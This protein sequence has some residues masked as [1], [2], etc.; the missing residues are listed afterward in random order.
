[1][2][3]TLFILSLFVHYAQ[4]FSQ[5]RIDVPAP[6]TYDFIRYGNIP[7]SQYT[8]GLDFSVP[9]YQYSDNDFNFGVDVR[10]NSSGFKPNKRSSAVGLDWFL[11]AGGSITRS[12]NG[13]PDDIV[14][15]YPGGTGAQPITSGFYALAKT[16]AFANRQLTDNDFDNLSSPDIRIIV[17]SKRYETKPDIFHF[18]F[19]GFSGKFFLDITGEI[20]V[21]ADGNFK[22]DLTDFA[23]QSGDPYMQEEYLM[24]SKIVITDDKG[25]IYTF[26]GDLQ[27]LEYSVSISFQSELGFSPRITSWNLSKIKAP[28]GR[29]VIFKYKDFIKPKINYPI[30]Q[31]H[32]LINA[33]K[34]LFMGYM[35]EIGNGGER[36]EEKSTGPIPGFDT[37]YGATKTCYLE[38][39]TVD[40]T[41]INFNYLANNFTF[42]DSAKLTALSRSVKY[43]QKNLRLD[44]IQI[45]YNSV[46]IKEF[47]LTQINNGNRLFLTQIGEKNA[48]P[49]V[50]AYDNTYTSLPYPLTSY[51]DY[52]GFW[53]GGPLNDDSP[54]AF[55][56]MNY[57]VNGD[58]T[59]TNSRRDPNNYSRAGLLTSVTYPTK[60]VSRFFY[61]PHSYA[62]MLDRRSD[63]QFFP[64]LYDVNNLIAGGQRVWKI[65]DTDLKGI[66]QTREFKYIINSNAPSREVSSGILNF[67]PRYRIDGTLFS[68]GSSGWDSLCYYSYP[69]RTI[70]YTT[71][72]GDNMGYMNYNDNYI[73]YSEVAEIRSGHGMTVSKFNTYQTNPDVVTSTSLEGISAANKA[74]AAVHFIL[75]DTSIERGK[76]REKTSY[77]S[78]GNK[79]N[80]SLYTYNEDPNRFNSFGIAFNH[81]IPMFHAYR[82]FT[83]PYHLTRETTTIYDNNGL[84][85]I[86]ATK[87]S[88]YD[89]KTNLIK[90]TKTTNSNGQEIATYYKYPSDYNFKNTYTIDCAAYLAK[91]K[92]DN[93]YKCGTSQACYNA[94]CFCQSVNNYYLLDFAKVLKAMNDANMQY[95]IEIKQTLNDGTEKVISSSL[96]EYK[97]NNTTIVKSKISRLEKSNDPFVDSYIQD[98]QPYLNFINSKQYYENII[99]QD[100]Y[101]NG[102]IKEV[103][104]ANGTHT[105]YIWGYNQ[106]K[107]IAKIENATYSSITASLITATQTAS[108]TGTEDSLLTALNN[109]RNDTSLTNAMVTTY[110]HIPLVG[111]STITDP[112]GD[113][114]TYTYDEFN[115]LQFV[116]DKDGN[117]LTENEYHY[118]P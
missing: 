41:T 36:S 91:C 52:W 29:E 43:N 66:D 82:V 106:L 102:N 44:N 33:N 101:Q 81:V 5:E 110:T 79:V 4:S 105:V 108:D 7:V 11:N 26:G 85:P 31:N 35:Q 114:I 59:Y 25:Y 95:P 21:I 27:N 98:N 115:R 99:F 51:T 113:K 61:E 56:S 92:L 28:N 71:T 65:I 107:P 94:F 8:G 109:L 58:I 57:S 37:S 116:K 69:S 32:Y 75:D 2:K 67:W 46:I 73:T 96:T 49:Y 6:Q 76:L 100:Y 77:N 111:V 9:I 112:K 63:N 45:K 118:K 80:S 60:G 24:P 34:W 89:L 88:E 117:I 84:N 97:F 87:E 23:P 42:Y 13:L 47:G 103:S 50:F 18:N 86:S 40:N 62:L 19:M 14:D 78:N 30:D 83:Y 53:N 15:S 38:K 54:L 70:F 55:P 74:F 93:A 16:K 64:K 20:H 39:I 72:K 104:Q 48:N 1:M 68:Q 12:I 90:K 17:G 10:Y 22:I 3:K